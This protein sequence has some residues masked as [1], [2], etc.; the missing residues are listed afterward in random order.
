LVGAVVFTVSYPYRVI[1]VLRWIKYRRIKTKT[2]AYLK[3]FFTF[4]S[5]RLVNGD[6]SAHTIG[7]TSKQTFWEQQANAWAQRRR[8]GVTFNRIA[9][10]SQVSIPTVRWRLVQFGFSLKGEKGAESAN[11]SPG[12]V[13]NHATAQGDEALTRQAYPK[14]STTTP[15][16]DK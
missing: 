8:D 12:I 3:S 14:Q 15:G 1:A 2:Q 16:G 7:V 4:F 6:S 13:N 10:E 5:L 11:P 9:S